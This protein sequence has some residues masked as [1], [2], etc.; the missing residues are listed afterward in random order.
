MK[1]LLIF[2]ELEQSKWQYCLL[3]TE[4]RLH[5]K[6]SAGSSCGNP[7][8]RP[9]IISV[10][11]S[12]HWFLFLLWIQFQVLVFTDK[13]LRQLDPWDEWS[14][15]CLHQWWLL[16]L[17]SAI[18]LVQNSVETQ[19]SVDL[20]GHPGTLGACPEGFEGSLDLL[21][22]TNFNTW[23]LDSSCPPCSTGGG[24]N[25]ASGL[26]PIGA[27][28]SSGVYSKWLKWSYACLYHFRIWPKDWL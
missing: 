10:L 11:H 21:L 2:Y 19:L 24:S 3:R 6:S 27:I 22:T 13:S 12:C 28:S 18:I 25:C 20:K 9:H 23:L 5:L 14:C 8:W 1:I 7:P 26:K 17:Y 16:H 15:P 4:D